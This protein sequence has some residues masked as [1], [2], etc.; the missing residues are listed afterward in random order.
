MKSYI[1]KLIVKFIHDVSHN[2][3]KKKFD[4]LRYPSWDTLYACNPKQ[5]R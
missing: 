3:H 4:D 5:I 2:T 1:F